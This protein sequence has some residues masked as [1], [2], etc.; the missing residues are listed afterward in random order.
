MTFIVFYNFSQ[1]PLNQRF[2]LVNLVASAP[3]STAVMIPFYVFGRSTSKNGDHS[4]TR[5]ATPAPSRGARGGT[6]SA[7]GVSGALRRGAGRDG[8]HGGNERSYGND[9]FYRASLQKY[10][11]GKPSSVPAV[12]RGL[13]LRGPAT[14]GVETERSGPRTSEMWIFKKKNQSQLI[15]DHPVCSPSRRNGSTRDRSRRAGSEYWIILKSCFIS[16]HFLRFPSAPLPSL[17]AGFC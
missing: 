15:N 10:T 11:M 13:L 4:A 17:R 1:N 5:V 3:A 2:L 9:G 6:R 8:R 7:A 14:A 16:V 12:H